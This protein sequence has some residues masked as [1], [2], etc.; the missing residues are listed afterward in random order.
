MHGFYFLELNT[1]GKMDSVNHSLDRTNNS[2]FDLFG[3]QNFTANENTSGSAIM[4]YT[5]MLA[6][7]AYRNATQTRVTGASAS[8]SL[9]TAE[10][11]LV[12]LLSQPLSSMG[13]LSLPVKDGKNCDPCDYSTRL[14]STAISP[15]S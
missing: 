8:T 1:T 9:S 3:Y 13:S 7:V 10:H 12:P 2:I 11:I 6:P 14:V 4:D 5:V 15:T